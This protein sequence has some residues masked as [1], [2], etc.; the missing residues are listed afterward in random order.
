MSIPLPLTSDK[1]RVE[2]CAEDFKFIE[3]GIES[4][5][6]IMEEW[7]QDTNSWLYWWRSAQR[8]INKQNQLLIRRVSLLIFFVLTWI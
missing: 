8:E 2:L 5:V 1:E 6:D 4:V 3:K 7:T